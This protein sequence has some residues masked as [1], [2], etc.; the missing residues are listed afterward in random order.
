[1]PEVGVGFPCVLAGVIASPAHSE[2]ECFAAIKGAV[3]GYNVIDE[4]FLRV[5]QAEVPC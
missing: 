5:E 1:M 2:F 4:E 3:V